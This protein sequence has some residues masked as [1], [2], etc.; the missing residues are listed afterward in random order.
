MELSEYK[1][2]AIGENWWLSIQPDK[3]VFGGTFLPD[4]FHCTFAYGLKSGFID[5]HLSKDLPNNRK[6][7][8]PIVRI[9]TKDILD[10][11]NPL[12]L[13]LLNAA[14]I[15]LDEV[16]EEFFINDSVGF[17]PLHDENQ[18]VD[19]R[20]IQE[21][22]DELIVPK[23]RRKLNIDYKS[24]DFESKAKKFAEKYAEKYNEKLQKAERI[25]DM[26]F[27]TGV[28][29]KK[30][31]KRMFLKISIGD[32]YRIFL[33]D[34][35]DLDHIS[36]LKKFLGKDLFELLSSRFK[37]GL[38]KLKETTEPKEFEDLVL[39]LSSSSD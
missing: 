4:G 23:S 24:N 27:G 25:K 11:L 34:S 9:S 15:G 19:Q 7:H 28:L 18:P 13:R 17:I 3:M 38:E 33:L 37:E 14:L 30:D 2:I 5:L 10:C 8:F 16:S 1:R 32:T 20:F 39:K 22:I 26:N 21:V 36:V 35:I 31:L 6:A 29:I 12:K